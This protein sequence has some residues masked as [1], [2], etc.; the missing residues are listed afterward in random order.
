MCGAYCNY[1]LPT[2]SGREIANAQPN[3]ITRAGANNQ[4]KS[5]IESRR[6]PKGRAGGRAGGS[7]F[8]LQDLYVAHQLAKM[9]LAE[10]LSEVLWEKKSL[11]HGDHAGVEGV[12]VDDAILRLTR[13]RA[14]FV[15]VKESAPT[16]GWT[17]RELL[18]SGVAQQFWQQWI[19]R[20]TDPRQRRSLR[21]AARGDT[22]A[23]A[24]IAEAALRSETPAELLA[25]EASTEISG[26]IAKLA[27]GLGL[28]VDDAEFLGFLKSIE[29]EQILTATELETR[30]IESLGVFGSHAK[31][32]SR[33][34][35]RFVARSKHVGPAARASFTRETLITALL[36]DGFPEASLIAVGLLRAPPTSS[37]IWDQYREQV[38]KKFRSLRLYGL[39][40]DRAVYA[41][42]PALFVPL[43]L[44]AIPLDR[45]R[46]SERSENAP[47]SL[48]D[49]LARETELI[50]ED[51]PDEEPRSSS[52]EETDL[53]SV[54]DNHRRFAIISGPGTGKTTTLKWLAVTCSL[55]S[56]EGRRVR[57]AFGLGPDALI[58]V[59]VRFRQFAEHIKARG[60]AGVEGRAGLVAAFL[61]AE[62][63]SGLTG[64]ALPRDQSLQMAQHLLESEQSLFLFDG[65]DEV[66]DEATRRGL[67]EAVADLMAK[68]PSPRILVTSRP[69]AFRRDRAPLELALFEPLPLDREGRQLFAHQ[70]YRAVRATAAAPLTESETEM[71]SLDLARAANSM[72]DLA[73]NPLLLSILALVHF[74][75]DGLPLERALLYDNATIAMLGHWD[76][77]PA[78]RD[79]DDAIPPDWAEKLQ[80]QADEIRPVVERLAWHVQTQLSGGEFDRA[81]ALEGLASALNK[82]GSHI[83]KRAVERAQLLLRLLV[84]RAGLIQ[85]RSPDTFAFVHLTF[86]EYLAAR[87]LLA[88]NAACS[89]EFI[90]LASDP[91]QAEVCRL[92]IAILSSRHNETGVERATT[93]IRSITSSN[94]ALAAASLLEAP[95]VKLDE[96]LA[97]QLA[98]DTYRACTN[99]RRNFYLPDVV[100]QLVWAALKFGAESDAVLLTILSDPTSSLD[101]E[102][103]FHRRMREHRR[104]RRSRDEWRFEQRYDPV[105]AILAARP[106]KAFGATLQWVLHRLADTQKKEFAP[107]VCS[108][109]KLMLVEAGEAQAADHIDSLI[110]LLAQGH[111][112]GRGRSYTANLIGRV[113]HVLQELRAS[114]NSLAV[115]KKLYGAL[116]TGDGGEHELAWPVCAFLMSERD[117]DAPGLA[118]TLVKTGLALERTRKDAVRFLQLLLDREH[119]R[120]KAIEAL[121]PGLTSTHKEVSARSFDLL[122][123]ANALP[124]RVGGLAEK[125]EI[126]SELLANATTVGD[127]ISALSEDLWSD[128]NPTAWHAARKLIDTSNTS[129]PG[130]LHAAVH[131]GLAADQSDAAA[132]LQKLAREKEWAQHVRAE[133]LGAIKSSNTRVSASAAL[134]F[135]ELQR[136]DNLETL[137]RLVKAAFSDPGQIPDAVAVAGRLIDEPTASKAVMEALGDAHILG[138]KADRRIASAV[139]R[140][141]GRKGIFSIQD[142][143][144]ALITHGL[145]DE[146]HH[147]E[148]EPLILALLDNPKT[149]SESWRL[150]FEALSATEGE[151]DWGSVNILWEAG[152]KTD[153]RIAKVLVDPGLTKPQYR[154]RA[155]RYL[156]D[157]FKSAKSTKSARAA[158]EEGM[159]SALQDPRYHS[160]NPSAAWAMAEVLIEVGTLHAENLA[161]ALVIG[162]LHERGQHETTLTLFAR[163][164][165][166]NTELVSELEECLWEALSDK[167]A[168]VRWGAARALIQ[169]DLLEP[170]I[171]RLSGEPQPWVRQNTYAEGLRFS[172]LSQL[173]K[174]LM[175]ESGKDGI[176]AACLADLGRRT[177]RY[178]KLLD[179]LRKLLSENDPEGACA[180]AHLLASTDD[181][182]LPTVAAVL[183]RDGLSD[184]DRRSAA[185]KRLTDLLEN[186]ETAP[187][188]IGALNQGLWS[189]RQEVAWSSAVFWRERSYPP[190]LGVFRAI[191]FGGLLGHRPREGEQLLRKYLVDPSHGRVIIEALTAG[192]Y[193][194]EEFGS[195]AVAC[196]L[197]EAGAPIYRRTMAMLDE[198]IAWQP[199]APLAI[200]VRTNRVKEA[201][202]AAVSFGC[203]DLAHAIGALG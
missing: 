137:E 75:R 16:G 65:L 50:R 107:L 132:Y 172:Q 164:F 120:T 45:R 121:L 89:E 193:S 166:S 72:P 58:P 100:A 84:E 63:E 161:K 202:Q 126:L 82:S 41:D 117:W 93:L 62:L 196:L 102:R 122:H 197:I 88:Q 127:T 23:L 42:L 198:M 76:R 174:I 168:D 148:L 60:L 52:S 188:V 36:D 135:L 160:R 66:G 87:H 124:P 150:L 92:A 17:A 70:W 147:K 182:S 177:E 105:L 4:L 64:T 96:E 179:A 143:P 154:E 175:R 103:F 78:G 111:E 108:L 21:L 176:A 38:T 10:E 155:R 77:D 116:D 24:L 194:E 201:Q 59:Y 162:G 31:D 156:L 97:K 29:A 86:Q 69:Y 91:R 170:E 181:D 139:G 128:S 25:D 189:D 26:E 9:L 57:S 22:G 192:L 112:G 20:P 94:P 159:G 136:V 114:D 67:F 79:L 195:S 2:T 32:L 12:H 118:F 171:A 8:D 113:S 141:L 157:L 55:A 47:Q 115:R 83:E 43:K 40:V 73:E 187:L 53:R 153:D 28:K 185:G 180:A 27:V 81:Q 190:N 18:R 145:Y 104:G 48:A 184:F 37:K 49:R 1:A 33:R 123:E 151:A 99:R 134:L 56:D 13:N 98:I 90:R 61:S 203:T 138:D 165:S 14:I 109:A 34:L 95:D 158:L 191:V 144:R 183:V 110:E 129:V 167:E 68:Y 80:L 163:L 11:D 101:D 149:A 44:S 199:S 173:W 15:Q 39:Q 106:R 142:L 46:T 35:I 51:D 3:T 7:G 119:S 133:L 146:A 169:N 186:H 54:L 140:M 200:L 130:V 19:S 71:R 30:T 74:N 131:S 178:P 6:R 152:R 125:P 5:R 85:E